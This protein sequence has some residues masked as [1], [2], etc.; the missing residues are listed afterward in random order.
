VLEQGY[1]LFDGAGAME[2]VRVG[3]DALGLNPLQLIQALLDGICL[4]ACH[5][6]SLSL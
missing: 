2:A 5:K 4:S 6:F 3:V 1:C